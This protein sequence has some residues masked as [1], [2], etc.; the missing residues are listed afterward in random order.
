MGGRCADDDLDIVTEAGEAVNHFGFADAVELAA[1]HFGEL[2]LRDSEN[3][4]GVL[5]APAT[6]LEDFADFGREFGLDQHFLGIGEAEVRVDVSGA[7]FEVDHGA[8]IIPI[9]GCLAQVTSGLRIPGTAVPAP[10]APP[11]FRWF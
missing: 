2:W 9:W 11:L 3:L 7:G 8:I 5:L 10:I 4:S 6:R 1:E